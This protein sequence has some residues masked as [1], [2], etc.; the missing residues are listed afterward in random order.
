MI[1]PLLEELCHIVRHFKVKSPVSTVNNEQLDPAYNPS[2]VNSASDSSAPVFDN[3]NQA[4]PSSSIGLVAWTPFFI[5]TTAAMLIACIMVRQG[6]SSEQT[7]LPL[8]IPMKQK[9]KKERKVPNY[10]T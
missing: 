1:T 2:H 4:F 6:K 3:V 10:N 8:S 7:L 5:F 9:K